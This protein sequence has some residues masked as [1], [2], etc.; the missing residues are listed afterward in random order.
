MAV[1]VTFWGVRGSFPCASLNHMKYGGNTSCVTFQTASTTIVLDAGTGL[2]QLGKHLLKTGVSAATLLLSHSHTDHI[3][4]FPFFAP[5]WINSFALTIMA[6]HLIDNGGVRNIFEVGMRDPVF[7][8]K[9]QDMG[10]AT[11]FE[12][13]RVGQNLRLSHDVRVKTAPLVHPNGATAYR[14]EAEGKALCY[15]TD[16]EHTPGKPDENILNLIKGADLVVYDCTYTDEEFPKKVGWGHSTWQEGV[17]LSRAAGAKRLAI[18]H[19]DPDHTD[20]VMDLVDETARHTWNK[21]FVAREGMVIT[22]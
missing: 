8:V 18:F 6:G 20:D 9:L 4:G 17:R 7:P 19:H 13:F 15:V 2:F 12:D 21:A 14:I 11:R 1:E 22:L 10:G 16:T 3:I 5:A